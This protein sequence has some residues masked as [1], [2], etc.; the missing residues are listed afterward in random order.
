MTPTDPFWD[1]IAD[2]YARKPIPDEA[3]YQKKLQITRGYLRPDMK[4]LEIGCGTGSTAIAHAP[5]VDHV[6]GIDVSSKMIE[7]ALEKQ[8]QAGV[9]NMTLER[10]SIDEFSAADECY[11]A[12]LG[13]SILHLVA[14]K[15]AV[16]S[17][18]FRMLKPGGVFVNSTACLGDK[19]KFFKVIAPIGRFLRLLPLLKVFTVNE[20]KASLTQAGF[21][22]DH[23][24]SPD[25]GV[26]VF[27]VAKK[28]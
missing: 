10:A 23:E 28:P 27:I 13:L 5:F 9:G 19:M 3:A 22:I 7:I 14:D 11:D 16:I 24:W 15:E 20:L 25:K 18:V 1:R 12:I 6:H 21:K 4:V 17:K 8:R 26:A 2:R